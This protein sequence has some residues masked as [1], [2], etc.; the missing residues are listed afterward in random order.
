MHP[1]HF[2]DFRSR[3]GEPSPAL[4]LHRYDWQPEDIGRFERRGQFH[5]NEHW[6][7]EHQHHQQERYR[8]QHPQ[9]R[10]EHRRQEPIWRQQDIHFDPSNQRA[11]DRWYED[12]T[13]PHPHQRPSR[14][15]DGFWEDYED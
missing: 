10:E 15:Y 3:W 2:Q 14:H 13:M 1:D 7:P 6:R 8:Q 9:H 4:D 11:E 12:P 5:R